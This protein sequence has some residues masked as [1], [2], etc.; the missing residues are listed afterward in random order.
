MNIYINTISNIAISNKY[1]RWY[2]D[3]CTSRLETSRTNQYI[4]KHHI[5]P[6]SFKLGGEKDTYNL[7]S[8]TPKEHFLAHYLL[9]K[10]FEQ[11]I[12]KAKMLK[13]MSKF[14]QNNSGQ[15]RKLNSIQYNIIRVSAAKANQLI[16]IGSKR[17]EKTKLL[18]SKK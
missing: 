8:F 2:I 3:L 11:K 4:E 9:S 1:T 6:K 12:Y 5:L 16:N 14:H 10:M 7:V 17:S 13:A 15:N 18:M